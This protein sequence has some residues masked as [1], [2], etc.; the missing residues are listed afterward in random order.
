LSIKAISISKTYNNPANSSTAIKAV[1]S[2][3]LDLNEGSFTQIFGPTG[4]GK[5]TLI[6]LLSGITRPT[7]G[8]IVFN[9][10]H[11]SSA[12]DYEIASF[13]E[14]YIGYVPQNIL[15]IKN[16]N[17][18]ENILSP[19]VFLRGNIKRLKSNSLELLERLNLISKAEFDPFELA[20]GEKKKVLLIRALIKN[21]IYIMA[22]EPVA[23]LDD[24]SANEV[25]NLLQEYQN[26]G[27]AVMLVSHKPLEFDHN[28]DLYKM[29]DGKIIDYTRRE[30][31]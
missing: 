3:S 6:S 26:R 7:T 31:Q 1:D 20:G 4:S 8:E 12:K 23:E 21:P 30:I 15:F 2:V 19:N 14:R 17:V 10:I 22:D 13:R 27:S 9:N 28:I 25:L 18:I 5:T 11:L 29:L 24:E 16:L